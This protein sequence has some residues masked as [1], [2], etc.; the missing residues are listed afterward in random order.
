M[1]QTRYNISVLINTLVCVLMYSCAESTYVTTTISFTPKEKLRSVF[2]TGIIKAV[3]LVKLESDGCIV[4]NIDKIIC[5]DSLLYIL[6]KSVTKEVYIYTRNGQYIN[7]IS[8]YGHGKYEYTQ[9]YDIFYDKVINALCLLSRA[10]QKIISFTPDGKRVL[11]EKQLPKAFEHVVPMTNG[12]IGYMGNYSQNS[13]LPYNVWTMDKSFNLLDGFI[14]INP[15]L[16]SRS[17]SGVYPM[18]AYGDAMYFKPEYENNIYQIKD[19][20]V[21]LRYILDFGEKTFPGLSKVSLDNKTEWMKLSMEKITNI[22]NYE[23]TDDF[24]LMDFIMN[25]QTHLGIYNKYNHSSEIVRL[26]WYQ[27]EYVFPFGRIRGMDQSA[28][29]SVVDNEGVYNMW[30]GHNKVANFEKMYPQQ[31]DNLRKLFP[32]L[33]E[34]GNPFI[35]IYSLK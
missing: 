3:N 21:S 15:Q 20:E 10:D 7:K 35:A 16:E 25:G 26:D 2:D 34:N 29:Y 22:Y 19:G 23:E 4:G 33:E 6:D 13:S 17:Y 11:G 28:I 12:Y 18:S 30:L 5:N 8:R 14:Q 27:K 24:I 9:L 1:K 32:H 31:V